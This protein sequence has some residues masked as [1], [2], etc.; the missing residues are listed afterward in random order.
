MDLGRFESGTC[1]VYFPKFF[2]G[3][4][5]Q[6]SIFFFQ[7]RDKVKNNIF[8]ELSVNSSIQLI[9][10]LD[11]AQMLSKPEGPQRFLNQSFLTVSLNLVHSL[12]K[13]NLKAYTFQII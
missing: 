8:I 5:W 7:I 6:L 12:A 4:G 13:T 2:A 1:N 11:V 9:T 3:K 10:W